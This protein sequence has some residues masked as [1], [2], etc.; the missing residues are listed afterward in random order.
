MRRVGWEGG[1]VWAWLL[2]CVQHGQRVGKEVHT[3]QVPSGFSRSFLLMSNFS[4][5]FNSNGCY[6]WDNLSNKELN[7]SYVYD[8]R[9]RITH[10]GKLGHFV[11]VG[12]VWPHFRGGCTYVMEII[13]SSS[14]RNS[15]SEGSW[16][17][18]YFTWR[19]MNGILIE[20]EKMGSP[21]RLV[22]SIMFMCPKR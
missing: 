9:H 18:G 8:I 13:V 11:C 4:L 6:I 16:V 19:I 12:F 2:V 14:W 7:R 3:N 17:M 10:F 20:N 1:E 21:L 22:W 15:S 5:G